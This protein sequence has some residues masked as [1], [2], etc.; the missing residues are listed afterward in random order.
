MAKVTFPDHTDNIGQA[1]WRRLIRAMCPQSYLGQPGNPAE[2][3]TITE[4]G[5]VITIG[6][7]EGIV[8]GVHIYDDSNS[9]VTI[10]AY[11]G[12]MN[13]YLKLDPENGW[14]IDGQ[15]TEFQVGT[16]AMRNGSPHWMQSI[17]SL[18]HVAAGMLIDTNLTERATLR[19]ATLRGPV[20]VLRP[21]D[22][23]HAVTKKY[24]DEN[25]PF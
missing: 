23:A 13:R 18:P 15:D 16:I 9:T 24:A 20:L 5:G 7:Y 3:P 12:T 11:L 21:T 1:D 10:P 25:F 8:D 6:P 17:T 19:G 14:I 4:S 22:E 2:S